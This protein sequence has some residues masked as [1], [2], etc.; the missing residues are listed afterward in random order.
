MRPLTLEQALSEEG[1]SVNESTIQD[2]NSFKT[3]Q[4]SA[5]Y[6]GNLM[7]LR[8][9]HH[10]QCL[11]NRQRSIVP[12][13]KFTFDDAGTLHGTFNCNGFQQGYDNMVHGGVI[14]AIIDASMA[15]CLM[16]HGVVG[17]TANL[18]I[19]YRKPVKIRTMAYLETSITAINC[20][21]LHSMKC[22][23]VQNRNLVVQATGRFFKVK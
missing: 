21:L 4:G 18:S 14:A 3:S 12:G 1:G 2:I 16:G 6:E 17:Y 5:Y 13:L 20:G 10:S 22:E 8:E 11:F 9:I 15:Q 19:K 23:I 7:R